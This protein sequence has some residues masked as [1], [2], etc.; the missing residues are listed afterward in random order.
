[1]NINKFSDS[2]KPSVGQ[3]AG[4]A[5]DKSMGASAGGVVTNVSNISNV[6]SIDKVAL[7]SNGAAILSGLE[8][9]NRL[10]QAI[11]DGSYKINTDAIATKLI[12]ENLALLLKGEN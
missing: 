5:T 12:D 7:S 6:P 8:K 11:A 1:M 9:V 2:V 3:A 10:R 4:P